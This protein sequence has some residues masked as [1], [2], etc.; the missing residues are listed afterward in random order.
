MILLLDIDMNHDHGYC[1]E[2]VQI[3]MDPI[4]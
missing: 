2:N 4:S 1:I 3:V